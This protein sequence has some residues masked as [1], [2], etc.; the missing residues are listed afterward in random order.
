[1]GEW[2][3]MENKEISSS[4]QIP[5]PAQMMERQERSPRSTVLERG[6]ANGP[7]RFGVAMARSKAPASIFLRNPTVVPVGRF[8]SF[9]FL[10]F[11]KY[12]LLHWDLLPRHH[13]EQVRNAVQSGP[14]FVVGLH[15]IPRG[16][17]SIRRREHCVPGA[18]VV[19]P[20]AMRLKIHRA[21]FP[22]SHRILDT[23]EEATVLLLFANL[24]PVF[25][26]DNAIVL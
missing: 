21:Y 2:A 4:G 24:K 18:R 25:D 17:R 23:L 19:V 9:W 22:S 13:T 5:L 12:N 10:P 14:H 15:H 1:M 16:L 8:V 3:S 11:R 7:G 6:T 20:A 26:E